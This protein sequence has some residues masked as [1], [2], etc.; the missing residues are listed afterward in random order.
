MRRSL[1]VL[2]LHDLAGFL[3]ALPGRRL[4]V[5][6]LGPP[7][8]QF[9]AAF[10]AGSVAA[11]VVDPHPLQLDLLDVV[12]EDLPQVFVLSE[13]KEVLWLGEGGGRALASGQGVCELDGCHLAG[14]QAEFGEGYMLVGL[15]FLERLRERR[16]A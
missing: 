4:E 3:L 8:G 1:V 12:L 10:A 5:F 7:A 13:I 6:L 15:W 11:A 16:W 9:L 2:H 14:G